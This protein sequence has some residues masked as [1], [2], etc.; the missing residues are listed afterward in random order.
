MNVIIWLF[1][2][3]KL[4]KSPSLHPFTLHNLRRS[5]PLFGPKRKHSCQ[6]GQQGDILLLSHLLYLGLPPWLLHRVA[7]SLLPGPWIGTAVPCASLVE[8]SHPGF[9]FQP[10]FLRQLTKRI[11]LFSDYLVD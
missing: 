6:H 11:N 1:A 5:L 9:P 10:P 7:E 4:R 3:H 8:P 2:L